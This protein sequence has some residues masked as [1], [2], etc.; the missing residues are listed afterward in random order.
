MELFSRGVVVIRLR[1]LRHHRPPGLIGHADRRNEA[2]VIDAKRI[3]DTVQICLAVAQE[4]VPVS[5]APIW[6]IEGQNNANIAVFR[7]FDLGAKGQVIGRLPHRLVGLGAFASVRSEEHTSELQS[8]MLI[9]YAVF[10]LKNK[11]KS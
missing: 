6:R 3:G 8:L 2:A 1:Y 7:G 5:L 10:C 11:K 4:V 9:S